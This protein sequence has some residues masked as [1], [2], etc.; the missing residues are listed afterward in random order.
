MNQYRLYTKLKDGDSKFVLV[1]ADS[2]EE[3]IGKVKSALEVEK[4]DSVD[5]VTETF[6]CLC[7]CIHEDR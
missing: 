5:D 3:A 4:I 2:I 1:K 6:V 7:D